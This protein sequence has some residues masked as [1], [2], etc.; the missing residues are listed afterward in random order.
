M[1]LDFSKLNFFSKLDARARV[2]FLFAGVVAVVFVVYLG[3]RFLWGG[4]ETGGPTRVA[5]A[6]SGLQSVPGG[7]LTPEYYRALQQ[8]NVQAKK[9]AEISGGSA[10]PT[11]I[12]VGGGQPGVAQGSAQCNIIC[13]DQ[14]ANVKYSL[15]D[16]V[17]Q[18]KVS[19]DVSTALQQLADQYVPIDD[20]AT[21]LD[22]LAQ[23][24][25]L[26]P[27]QA[28]ELLEQYK[29]QRANK[30]LQDSAK[31]MDNLI[32]SGQLPLDAANQLLTEQKNNILPAQYAATLQDL[33]SQGK[34]TKA[35]AQQLLA[36]YS[37]Q[38]AKEAAK[39]NIA[40]IQK[41]TNAGEITADIA[42]E[43]TDLTNRG[44]S[45]NEYST[46]LDR[47]V[48]A[49][50]LTPV[51]SNKLLDAYRK[52][53]TT[54]GPLGTLNDLIQQA[55][56]AAYQEISD[57]LKA[58]TI[59]QDVANLLNDMIQKNVSLETHQSTINQLVQQKKLSPEI[60]KLK[61]AD[62][63]LIKKLRDMADQ[64][65]ALQGNN[66]PPGVYADKL[67]QLVQ[68]GALSPDQAT[69]LM[70]EYQAMSAQVA[71]PIGTTAPGAEAFA[72]LQQR[73]QQIETPTVKTTDF[74]AAEQQA[75]TLSAQDKQRSKI[76]RSRERMRLWWRRSC[77]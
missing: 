53:K 41:M 47:A 70:Q 7:Q 16:W 45:V 77:G 65:G 20:Y 4:G 55:E 10:I 67:K 73:A 31:V 42:K 34:I 63:Q 50:K 17:R 57:L 14:T 38:Q 52:Q 44:A 36:Q 43:L 11:L 21:H 8:A 35:T 69:Q 51:A 27:E 30:L 5:K 62:Y 29:K 48:K 71:T 68:S 26:T 75:L 23:T 22:K 64:L 40:G 9:Q 46:A 72:R 59:T 54:I 32:K 33:V 6:P 37:Q 61:I 58:G 60:A 13:S 25:K 15:D 3:T 74:S 1:A 56:A 19:P 66:A 76:R 49:G 18:G 2:F 24:G 28:R 12:N 39:E